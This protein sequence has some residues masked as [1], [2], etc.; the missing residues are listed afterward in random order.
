MLTL[1][2]LASTAK[3]QTYDSLIPYNIKKRDLLPDDHHLNCKTCAIRYEALPLD[4]KD[5]QLKEIAATHP[6]LALR[7]MAEAVIEEFAAHNQA[8]VTLAEH[9][10]MHRA[11]EMVMA[12]HTAQEFD[13]AVL[14]LKEARKKF[15]KLSLDFDQNDKVSK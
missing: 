5:E 11:E 4:P 3:D 2:S 7:A 10:L 13:Q 1:T 9:K 15:V 8:V 12:R 6:N 14:R